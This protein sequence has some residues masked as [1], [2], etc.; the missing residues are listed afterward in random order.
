MIGRVIRGDARHLPL[1]DASVDA[2]VCDPPYAL[3]GGFMG[4]TWDRYD[5]RED[6]GFAYWLMG[7]VDGEGHFGIKA[8]RGGDSDTHVPFFALKL[9]ADEMPTLE[10]IVRELRCGQIQMEPR[11]GGN[12]LARW[13]VQSK[14]DCQRLMD[15]IDKYGLRAKK[16]MDYAIWRDAVCEWT[17]RPRGNRWHG[18]TDDRRMRELKHRMETVRTYVDPPW[19]G[20]EFQ[21]WCRM[22]ATEAF[23]V[24]RPGGHLLAFGGTRTYHR[25]TCAIEDAGFEIRD[26]IGVLGWV[27]AQGFPKSRDVSKDID[28]MAGAVREERPDPR[29]AERYPNGNGGSQSPMLRQAAHVSG[30]PMM[31]SSPATEDAARWQGWG[32]AL[33]PAW[34]PIVVA[35]KPLAGAIPV[36]ANIERGLRQRGIRGDIAW[37][38]EPAN[39]AERPDPQTSSSSTGAQRAAATS[40]DLAAGS[41]TVSAERPTG[42]GSEQR[43]APGEPPIGSTPTPTSEPRTP[44][45][46]PLS[47]QPTAGPA[48]AAVSGRPSSSP[49]TTSAEADQLTAALSTARSTRSSDERDSRPATESFAGIATGLTGSRMTVRI[50]RLSDGTFAWPDDLPVILAT[51]STVAGNVLAYGTGALNVDAC[52]VAHVNDADRAESEA[53]NRHADFGSG[54]RDNRVYGADQRDRGEA[55]NYSGASGRWPTNLVFVHHPDCQQVGVRTVRG[56][57]H[58]PARRGR[59]DSYG[60]GTFLGQDNLT[61]R[62]ADESVPVMDCV[63]GCHVAELDAQ[64]GIRTSGLYQPHHADHG[65]AAGRY[66]AM[67]GRERATATYG[68]T[69]GASRFYPTFR[70]NPKADT[71]ERPTIVR[72]DGSVFAHPTVKPVDLMRWLVRLVTPPGGLVLDPFAGSG[73]TLQAAQ[74]EGFRVG[75]GRAGPGVGGADPGPVVVGGP[76][77]PGRPVRADPPP[78]RARRPDGPPRRPRGPGMTHPP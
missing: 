22:W 58:H 47:S 14:P 3:P 35:R 9:R 27:H 19:S 31:T 10:Y 65:K 73:A 72:P 25:L 1:P 40:A 49:S 63:P 45:S 33:K 54:P 29:W 36:R 62:H 76:G 26:G 74:V 38:S 69:G 41:V 48:P 70:F 17:N 53:K 43:A 32:T 66:G 61:E 2:V 60:G 75:R 42:N 39:G 34:E 8:Q 4:R 12:P 64:S 11:E 28:A 21:D 13:V 56:D 16:R 59:S 71:W 7:L 55:G 15:V 46:E 78:S 50:D 44:N 5:G 67:A 52:R 23:R 20:H 57:G 6:A 77:Q 37:T 68:D 51:G 30:G 18:P 24:L